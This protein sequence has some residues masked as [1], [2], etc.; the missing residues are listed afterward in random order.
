[1]DGKPTTRTSR[2]ALLAAAGGAAA[3]LAAESLARPL[4]AAATDD[5]PL[6]LGQANTATRETSLDVHY[7]DASAESA[8]T[9][10]SMATHG[11]VVETVGGADAM[12]VAATG[13][14]TRGLWVRSEVGD[15][16]TASSDGPGVAVRALAISNQGWALEAHGRVKLNTSGLGTVLKGRSSATVSPLARGVLDRNVSKILVT[17]MSNPKGLQLSHVE[18]GPTSG[19]GDSLPTG[20]TV[21]LTAKAKSDV[22]FAW[23]VI[24]G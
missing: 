21:H 20:F 12:R 16:I 7:A 13:H 3:A 17:L 9:V 1:M 4:S 11:I 8:F 15:T 23:F 10:R 14:D 19:L 5:S 18:I 24:S 6:T 22:R 2:R